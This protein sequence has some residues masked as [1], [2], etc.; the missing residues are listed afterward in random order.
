M[1]LYAND[2]LGE[3]IGLLLS[4]L[5]GA[6]F[7]FW[8][9]RAGFGSSRKLTAIF[10]LRDFAVLKVMFS[11]MVTAAL[12]LQLLAVTGRIDLAALY[13]P[14]SI[15]WPQLVGGL[16]FGVG[17]VAG[18]WCPGTAAV[19]L[20]SGK[21]DALVF[22]IGAGAGSLAFAPLQPRLA[23][24]LHAGACSVGSLPGQLGI[25]GPVGALALA[26]IALAA[27]VGATAV[28]RIMAKRIAR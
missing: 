2:M 26:A 19:G 10:Y 21:L 3:P 1:N 25:S 12:G 13:V 27:F 28:E 17:F 6:A 11:A 8:L 24:F 18:G 7:G 15:V 9:E 14:E 23:D 22:L 16:L 4:L 20:A 5:I